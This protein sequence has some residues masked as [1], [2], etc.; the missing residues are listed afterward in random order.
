MHNHFTDF[1]TDPAMMLFLERF[2]SALESRG[3]SGQLRMLNFTCAEK[4]RRR[5]LTLTRP[6]REEELQFAVST[7]T[8][9]HIF[10]FI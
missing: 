4:A 2:E 8:M 3:M 7:R 6:S 5:T 9:S 1:E 10:L